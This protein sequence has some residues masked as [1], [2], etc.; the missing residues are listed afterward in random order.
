[1]KMKVVYS[2]FCFFSFCGQ[3]QLRCYYHLWQFAQVTRCK[4]LGLVF[5][6]YHHLS[7][8]NTVLIKYHISTCTEVWRQRF[9]WLNLKKA[10]PGAKN[11]KCSFWR[12]SLYQGIISLP[13]S[14]IVWPIS[15]VGKLIML[16]T[17]K[18]RKK[19]KK[20]CCCVQVISVRC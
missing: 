20:R 12:Q 14:S 5:V 9:Q 3:R 16:I 2:L 6:V 8:F 19:K 11:L 4:I 7:M 18:E 10:P 1:M 17:R 13:S 15:T